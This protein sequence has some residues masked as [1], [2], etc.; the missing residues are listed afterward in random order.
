MAKIIIVI[1]A[2]AIGIGIASPCYC[3]YG[4]GSGGQSGEDGNHPAEQNV[5]AAGQYREIKTIDGKIGPF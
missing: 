2:A 1:L 3:E 4:G 5:P